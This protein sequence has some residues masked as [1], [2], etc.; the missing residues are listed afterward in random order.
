[1]SAKFIEFNDLFFNNGYY[2]RVFDGIEKIGEG[3]YGTVYKVNAKGDT[4]NWAIKRLSLKTEYKTD[5]LREMNRFSVVQRLVSQYVVQYYYSWLE[6]N[7]TDDIITL[8]IRME[9]CDKTL[10]KLTIEI[11]NDSNIKDNE[12][13]TQIGYYI[14][15]QLFIE[16]L[17]CVF[18]L[19]KNK[20]I[21][22]DLN[23]HNIMIKMNGENNR[24]IK[25]CD[26]GL[27]AIHKFAQQ[28][29]TKDRGHIS[30]AA[31]EV[32]IGRKYDTKA[33]IYSLG[34]ILI[35]LFNIDIDWYENNPNYE[36][37]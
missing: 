2:E 34:I 36:F 30:Y 17:E 5:I 26:F 20:I 9:L 25:I 31:P 28:S 16:I 10:Q 24:F 1:M 7:R 29:H 8:Y 13:L 35:N 15:S 3:S 21:H 4:K 18:Y 11:N 19:H 27:I 12:N 23:P 37:Y 6:N 33:D 14:A 22:R 32:L